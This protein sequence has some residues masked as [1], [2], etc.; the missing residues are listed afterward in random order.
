V[1]FDDAKDI[2]RLLPEG[3]NLSSMEISSVKIDVSPTHRSVGVASF[4]L[5]IRFSKQQLADFEAELKQTPNAELSKLFSDGG[6]K[7][8]M[9][10]MLAR[11]SDGSW[12][13]VCI[14]FPS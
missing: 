14:S 8:S 10:A 7:A 9:F 12:K 4:T 3:K 13:I 2:R 6:L 11:N 1:G 5:N